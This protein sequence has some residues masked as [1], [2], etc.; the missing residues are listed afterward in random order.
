LSRITDLQTT[1]DSLESSDDF[2]LDAVVN[3]QATQGRA[4]LATGAG[5]GEDDRSGRQ[6]KVGAGV[7]IMPLLPPSSSSVRPNLAATVCAT[8]MPI[9]VE[10]LRR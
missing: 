9:L 5:G 10:L 7:R 6:L 2:G 8:A 1:V 3:D 4:A